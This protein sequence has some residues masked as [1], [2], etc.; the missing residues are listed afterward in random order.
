MFGKTL[1]NMRS[2]EVDLISGITYSGIVINNFE[3][4][5]LGLS[6]NIG[7][8]SANYGTSIANLQSHKLESSVNTL[9]NNFIFSSLNQ[10]GT[11]GY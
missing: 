3:Q 4:Y 5:M 1:S 2:L 9:P 11:L 7:I 10:V 6:G 8:T